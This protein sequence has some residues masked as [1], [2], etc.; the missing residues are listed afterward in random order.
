M[1]EQNS[2]KLFLKV[3]DITKKLIDSKKVK[4]NF[5]ISL[6]KTKNKT[7]KFRIQGIKEPMI[8]VPDTDCFLDA[9]I[10]NTLTMMRCFEAMAREK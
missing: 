9:T 5:F 1:G 8:Y 3:C 10:K 4:G 7:I 2:F 6:N